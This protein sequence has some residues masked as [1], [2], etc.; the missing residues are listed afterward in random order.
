MDSNE[1]LTEAIHSVF[2]ENGRQR[3]GPRLGC[4]MGVQMVFNL[5]QNQYTAAAVLSKYSLRISSNHAE[6]LVNP[7][8]RAKKVTAVGYPR[9]CRIRK[10]Q[11]SLLSFFKT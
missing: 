11:I 1:P 7:K 2:R 4:C 3:F 5:G 9:A 10:H 8:M 6:G